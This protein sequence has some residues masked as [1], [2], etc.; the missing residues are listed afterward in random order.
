MARPWQVEYM[1]FL[2]WEIPKLPLRIPQTKS[3]KNAHL[4]SGISFQVLHC[5]ISEIYLRPFFTVEIKRGWRKWMW[6]LLDLAGKGIKFCGQ[7]FYFEGEEKGW[8]LYWIPIF[9]GRQPW[10]P[11]LLLLAWIY[12]AIVERGFMAAYLKS[13]LDGYLISSL[14]FFKWMHWEK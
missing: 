14:L 7:P 8:H 9:K 5:T 13:R 3:L 2:K 11:P 4:A 6:I 12:E 10:R 1:A